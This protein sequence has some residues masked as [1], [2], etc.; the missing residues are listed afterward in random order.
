[1]IYV[2]VFCLCFPLEVLWHPLLHLGHYHLGLL[3]Y[4]VLENVLSF[5]ILDVIIQFSWCMQG[6]FESFEHLWR[7]WGLILN[8]I[9][10]LLPSC[11]GF[12]FALGHRYLLKVADRQSA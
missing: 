3:L 4:I 8:V 12:F 10:P 7:V 2:R 11:W 9:S 6:L 1:M 5:I